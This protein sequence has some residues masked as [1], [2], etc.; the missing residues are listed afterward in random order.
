MDAGKAISWRDGVENWDMI[1]SRGVDSIINMRE[2]NNLL[3]RG[4]KVF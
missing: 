4:G 1:V 3:E 2:H